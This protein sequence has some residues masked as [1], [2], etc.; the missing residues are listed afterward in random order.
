MVT[1]EPETEKPDVD[2]SQ[3]EKTDK[4]VELYQAL[5]L[6]S[7]D[8]FLFQ[9]VLAELSAEE[10]AVLEKL[11][12][13]Y[14]EKRQQSSLNLVGYRYRDDLEHGIGKRLKRLFSKKR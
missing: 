3:A 12:G 7:R 13:A 6:A 2:Q 4:V 1:E 5:R 9:S 14:A 8:A 10:F 11:C